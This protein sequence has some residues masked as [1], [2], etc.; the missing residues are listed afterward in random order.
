[1]FPLSPYKT[2]APSQGLS[3]IA[4][5]N[6]LSVREVEF[7]RGYRLTSTRITPDYS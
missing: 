2:D 7:A 1:M 5:K 6:A 4:H 3:F